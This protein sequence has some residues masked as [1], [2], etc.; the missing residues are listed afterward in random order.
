MLDP[1][2]LS[3]QNLKER[4]THVASGVEVKSE[5]KEHQYHLRS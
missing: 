3:F 4:A 2:V 5:A 1:E